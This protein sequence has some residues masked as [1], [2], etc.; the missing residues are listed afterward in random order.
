MIPLLVAVGA[1]GAG[2]GSEPESPPT[3]GAP[4]DREVATSSRSAELPAAKPRPV[5]VAP[6]ARAAKPAVIPRA[7]PA[8]AVEQ[9]APVLRCATATTRSLA[10]RGVAAVLR[11]ASPVH[12]FP[13]GPV[14]T[15]FQRLNQN[16]VATTFRV[17][18]ATV[19]PDCQTPW[20]RVQ[21]PM[22]PNG[23]TAWVRASAVRRYRVEYRI[24][25]DLSDRRITVF[26]GARTL[27]R[28]R[29]AIGRP[30]T[31][32][33]VGSFY[34]NQRL[35]TSDPTGPWGPGGIG[36]SAFSPVLT[37]WTQG[38]PIGIHGTNQPHTIGLAAS[39]GCLRIPNAVLSRLIHLIPD[40]TPV[41]IR[42]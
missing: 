12:V 15:T 34:V 35:L 4:P 2:C 32:T 42:A 19:G 10:D 21:I 41:R 16:G 40:G 28:T 22:R 23:A 20:Y 31:P 36:V 24:L 7:T 8:P 38:G 14:R 1:L 3:A 6:S 13:G 29:T 17:L 30:Q 33:P 37:G 27:L 9:K 26:H 11:H 5:P 18:G 25:V 39:N